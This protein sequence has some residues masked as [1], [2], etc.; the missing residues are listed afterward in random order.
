MK[1]TP[2]GSYG[3][4]DI[5]NLPS[6]VEEIPPFKSVDTPVANKPLEATAKDPPRSTGRRGV[7]LYISCNLSE[8]TM[9]V[10][11]LAIV[12]PWMIPRRFYKKSGYISRL[13][14]KDE[15]MVA[16][17]V[18]FLDIEFEIDDAGP[19]G[20]DSELERIKSE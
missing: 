19:G 4:K 3:T 13:C 6:G 12:P 2:S 15:E 16:Y 1:E 8:V 5:A 10:P 7:R 11:I 20:C 14:G 9:D 18:L 17:C